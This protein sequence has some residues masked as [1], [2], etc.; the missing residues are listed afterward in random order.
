MRSLRF[1]EGGDLFQ[2][3]FIC[4]GFVNLSPEEF[5]GKLQNLGDCASKGMGKNKQKNTLQEQEM[6][7]PPFYWQLSVVPKYHGNC[8]TNQFTCLKNFLRVVRLI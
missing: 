2:L 1:K 6:E 4:L 3:A 5:G 8:T 7:K